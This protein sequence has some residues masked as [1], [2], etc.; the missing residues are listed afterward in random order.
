MVLPLERR[1]W[2]SELFTRG[3]SAGLLRRNRK[4]ATH[5]Q[6]VP[7]CGIHVLT[8]LTNTLM[9]QAGEE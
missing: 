7:M 2:D 4:L 6:K 9:Y 8:W 1:A 3:T 5:F